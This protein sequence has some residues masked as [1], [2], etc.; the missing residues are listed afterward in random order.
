MFLINMTIITIFVKR[1]TFATPQ[2][3]LMI[4]CAERCAVLHK[5]VTKFSVF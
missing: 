4:Y 1:G 2:K 3:S 5:Y